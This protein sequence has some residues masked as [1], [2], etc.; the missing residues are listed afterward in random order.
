MYPESD[1]RKFND[2]M[3]RFESSNPGFHW[4]WDEQALKGLTV[5]ISV[6]QGTYNGSGFTKIARLET[7][8]DVRK[9]LV[10]TMLP[11]APRSDA[12]YDPPVDQASGVAVVDDSE[13]PF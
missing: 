1:K 11:L 7:A 5:G 8:D 13:V 3:F 2:A 10:K 9:G 12:S 4:A 6:R